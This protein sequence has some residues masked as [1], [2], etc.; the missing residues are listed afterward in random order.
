MR[1]CRNK[2]RHGESDVVGVKSNP[3]PKSRD[4][5]VIISL[6]KNTAF[7]PVEIVECLEQTASGSDGN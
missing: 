1:K 3:R 7:S 4:R 5:L 6:Q 2:I